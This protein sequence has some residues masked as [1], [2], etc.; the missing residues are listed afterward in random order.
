MLQNRAMAALFADTV[1][2]P[3]NRVTMIRKAKRSAKKTDLNRVWADRVGTNAVGGQIRERRMQLKMTQEQLAAQCQVRGLNLSRGTL[4]KIEARI[5]F[6][7]ACELFIIAKVM[8]TRMEDFYP[9]GFG[10]RHVQ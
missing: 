9:P 3:F 8:Q 10:D 5:R 1:R 6:V 7:K 2:P 4:A